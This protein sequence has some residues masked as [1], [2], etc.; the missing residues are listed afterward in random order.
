MWI[1]DLQESMLGC[2]R[3]PNSLSA[4]ALPLLL[5]LCESQHLKPRQIHLSST[6]A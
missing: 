1:A 6:S 3:L 2:T 4:A 5:C